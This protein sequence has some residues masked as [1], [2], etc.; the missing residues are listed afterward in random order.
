M[1]DIFYE[2]LIKQEQT[3]KDKLKVS[4]LIFLGIIILYISLSL[5]LLFPILGIYIFVLYYL[6]LPIF[7]TEFEYTL[8]NN[9]LSIDIILNKEKR[10]NLKEINLKDALLLTYASSST[11]KNYQKAKILNFSSRQK[12]TTSYALVLRNREKEEII[13]LDLN[14]KLIQLISIYLSNKIELKK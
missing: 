8:L 13:I 5:P 3:L 10:K 11:L 6:K 14:D 7:S 1:T 4:F 12:N 2:H 9:E